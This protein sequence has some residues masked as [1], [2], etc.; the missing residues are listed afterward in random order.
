MLLYLQ[1]NCLARQAALADLRAPA[2][3]LGVFLRPRLFPAPGTDLP[4]EEE[5]DEDG[6][7][8]ASP[9]SATP[10]LTPTDTLY[11]TTSHGAEGVWEVHVAS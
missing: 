10:K 11:L 5:E 9:E 2:A 6:E 4:V 1:H 3:A 8:A 7:P